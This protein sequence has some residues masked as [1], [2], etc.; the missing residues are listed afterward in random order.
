[1]LFFIGFFIILFIICCDFITNKHTNNDYDYDYDYNSAIPS[2]LDSIPQNTEYKSEYDKLLHDDRWY[3]KREKIL[4]RDNHKCQWCG[5]TRNLQVHHKYYNIYP[6]GNKANP[7]DYP[8]DALMV[9]CDD[10]HVKY[11]NKYSV[12]TYYRKSY[13]HY[14]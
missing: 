7:W 8:D 2:W 10:C 3:D 14:E 5:N 13:K 1:M 9:L 11:H 6:N 4:D 12:K